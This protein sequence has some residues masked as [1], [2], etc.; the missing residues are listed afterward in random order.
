MLDWLYF[1]FFT[2]S[3]F[4][5]SSYCPPSPIASGLQ[6]TFRT[7]W[8]I[9]FHFERQN[10]CIKYD[11]SSSEFERTRSKWTGKCITKWASQYCKLSHN[12]CAVLLFSIIK[13]KFCITVLVQNWCSAD[14]A[15][16]ETVSWSERFCILDLSQP[17][18]NYAASK[19]Y[20]VVVFY[21]VERWPPFR[22]QLYTHMMM[23]ET[24]FWVAI[25]Y[26]NLLDRSQILFI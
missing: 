20:V 2:V 12:L 3:L 18:H 26:W 10:Q 1:R 24:S 9:P 16:H 8:S 13:S 7:I 19:K 15:N 22:P 14:K 23:P 21:S 5:P 25:A 4:P 6:Y 11:Y 17:P